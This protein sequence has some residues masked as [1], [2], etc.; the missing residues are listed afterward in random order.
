M[1][2]APL[3]VVIKIPPV[4][5]PEKTKSTAEPAVG[6]E[7]VLKFRLRAVAALSVRVVREAPGSRVRPLNCCVMVCPDLPAM[8]K[9]PPPSSSELAEL[10]IDAGAVP[11]AL[12]LSWSVP[13]RTMV[14]P[15]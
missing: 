3:A 15:L 8:S 10:I 4:P 9:V 13:P 11:S 5:M 14:L 2:P 7:M 6:R 1:S 12:K